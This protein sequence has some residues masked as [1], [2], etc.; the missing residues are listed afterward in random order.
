MVPLAAFKWMNRLDICQETFDCLVTE[1]K[2]IK[3]LIHIESFLNKNFPVCVCVYLNLTVMSKNRCEVQKRHVCQHK[4][5]HQS[6]KN[7]NRVRLFSDR[8]HLVQ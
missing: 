5:C 7:I 1:K 6:L 3:L 4:Y 8:I 2:V